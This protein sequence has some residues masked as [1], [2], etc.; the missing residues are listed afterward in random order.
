MSTNFTSPN[1]A[2]AFE[3]HPVKSVILSDQRERRIPSERMI[4]PHTTRFFVAMLLRIT[5]RKKLE[6]KCDCP[7][8]DREALPLV[9]RQGFSV[10]TAAD[11]LWL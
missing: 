3:M 5:T 11:G 4:E 8:F 6:P 9:S 1:R 10:F 7:T 2:I